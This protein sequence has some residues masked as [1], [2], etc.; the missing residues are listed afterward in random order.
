MVRERNQ[1]QKD[2]RLEIG[3][4]E[5]HGGLKSKLPDTKIHMRYYSRFHSTVG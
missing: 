3:D 5:E 1:E 4:L 2:K